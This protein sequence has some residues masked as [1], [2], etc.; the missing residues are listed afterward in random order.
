MCSAPL[1]GQSVVRLTGG[2]TYS[3]KLIDDGILGTKVQPALA[4]AVGLSVAL[5]TGK[6]PYRVVLE[7][8]YRS[9]QLRA[10]DSEAVTNLGRLATIDLL[11]L[12]EGPLR[13]HFRWQFGGGAVFYSP[14]NQHGLFADGSE[15]RWVIS[16][17][18]TWT[19]TLSPDFNVIVVGR[20]DFHEF[21]TP[22]LQSRGYAQSQ[23]V[24]RF[25]IQAGLERKF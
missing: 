8:D 6:G 3:S 7:G 11:V 12:G 5:P 19:Q 4:P 21:T 25:G 9:S 13:D 14:S 24:R 1:A 23:G 2:V 18:V 22:A 17:G 20:A 15:R 16:G 10:T